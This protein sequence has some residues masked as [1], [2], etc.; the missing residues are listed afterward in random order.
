MNNCYP[1]ALP[2]EMRA[3]PETGTKI[4]TIKLESTGKV[5]YVL[6]VIP[7]SDPAC[8]TLNVR[9]LTINYQLRL[10]QAGTVGSDDLFNIFL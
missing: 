7:V 2:D 5:R 3:S 6:H 9:C 4:Y 1:K 10:L 8:G